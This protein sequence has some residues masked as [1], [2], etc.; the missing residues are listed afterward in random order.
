MPSERPVFDLRDVRKVRA[1]AA[2]AFELNIP[3]L[4][5]RRGEILVL[6]GVSGSGKSTM[7]DLLAMTLQ[8]DRAARFEFAPRNGGFCD[9]RALWEGREV[10]RL[11][12]LRAAHIGYILQTGGLL[13]FL[14]VRDN[15]A[16]AC[17]LLGRR[18]TWPIETIAERLGIAQHLDSPPGKLSV[19]ERQRVAIARALVHQP[20]VVLADEPTASVDPINAE[21]IFRMLLDLV[22]SLGVT[23]II[24]SHDWQRITDTGLHALSHRIERDGPVTRSLFWN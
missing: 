21:A 10:N 6:R 24:A 3:K 17:R 15:I 19:G 12:N 4:I 7:L 9:L 20:S 13:P 5:A 22:Q 14:T 16:L 11:T 23:A 1:N 18:P 8:P 2:G